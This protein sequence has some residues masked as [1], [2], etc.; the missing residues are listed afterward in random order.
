M[1]ETQVEVCSFVILTFVPSVV[2]LPEHFLS[3]HCQNVFKF[4]ILFTKYSYPLKISPVPEFFEFKMFY[5]KNQKLSN[6]AQTK[7]CTNV[8]H[9]MLTID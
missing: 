6:A 3:E 2:T 9:K 1:F 8:I 5:I 7:N 4:D